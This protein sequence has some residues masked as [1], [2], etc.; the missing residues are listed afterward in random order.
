MLKKDRSR[1]KVRIVSKE[2][3]KAREDKINQDAAAYAHTKELQE[4]EEA[5]TRAHKE[6]QEADE[7]EAVYLVEEQ[8]AAEAEAKLEVTSLCL[9]NVLPWHEFL[10][11]SG[12]P[13]RTTHCLVAMATEQRTE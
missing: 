4:A 12:Q 3:M 7:A 6:R 1:V 5:E 9:H 11:S 8:Q 2:E 13:K 10:R